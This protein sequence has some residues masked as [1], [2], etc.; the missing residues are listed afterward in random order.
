MKPIRLAAIAAVLIA[1]GATA[2]ANTNAAGGLSLA[3]AF[4]EREAQPGAVGSFRV[5]NGSGE[6]VAVTVRARPWIQARSGAVRP[7]GRRTLPQVRL[8]ATAFT[9]APGASRTVSAT[10]TSTPPS[11]SVYGAIDVIGTP[12]DARPR[13][14]IVARYRL[15]G[16][17]RLNPPAAQRRRRVRVGVARV[18]GAGGAGVLV[19]VRNA[20]NTVEPVTGSARITGATGTLR[21]TIAAQRILPGGLVDLRLRR[22]RLQPGRYTARITLRQG[23]RQVA[24]VTRV[25]RAGG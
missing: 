19:P 11:G 21:S 24:A 15:L 10:L 8:G 3:P 7:N 5:A 17:L 25:F 13:N 20:G 6:T 23:G 2:A 16:G 1:S 22:G 9:L 4:L 12:Q 18:S 14:G